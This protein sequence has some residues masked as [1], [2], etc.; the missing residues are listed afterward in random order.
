MRDES[1]YDGLRDGRRNSTRLR[2]GYSER[3]ESLE[4]NFGYSRHTCNRRPLRDPT[5]PTTP[6]PRLNGLSVTSRAITTHGPISRTVTATLRAGAAS[7]ASG[8]PAPRPVHP[9]V[10][11]LGAVRIARR[12]DALRRR[13]DGR[14]PVLVLARSRRARSGDPHDD[15][16]HVRHRVRRSSPGDSRADCPARPSFPSVP[17]TVS[18]CSSCP[19]LSVFPW[20]PRSPTPA[21]RSRTWPR[22]SD[23]PRS[24]LST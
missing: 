5:P 23:G 6:D 22:W 2:D 20:R 11:H 3:T 24:R 1:I 15:R 21:E 7:G 4:S 14:Q 10:P 8:L 19:R 17:P 18:A 16:C 12:D 13:S 9:V